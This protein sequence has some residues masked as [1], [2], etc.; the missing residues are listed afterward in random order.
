MT[1][2]KKSDIKQYLSMALFIVLVFGGAI[3]FVSCCNEETQRINRYTARFPKRGD[4]IELNGKEIVVLKKLV[5]RTERTYR[6]RL[7]NGQI[8]EVMGSEIIDK[9]PIGAE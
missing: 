6:I 7:P 5:W 3:G 8:T 9:K 2:E 4:K 1:K